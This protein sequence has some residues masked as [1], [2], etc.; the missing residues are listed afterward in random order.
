MRVSV[1]LEKFPD[2]KEWTHL[3][4]AWDEKTGIRFF[5]NGRLAAENK[6]PAILD[7]PCPRPKPWPVRNG[8]KPTSGRVRLS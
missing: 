2:P 5:I 1:P 3:A 4:L 8:D 7:A 6:T